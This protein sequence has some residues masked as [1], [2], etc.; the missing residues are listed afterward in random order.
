MERNFCRCFG[1]KVQLKNF[2]FGPEDDCVGVWCPLHSWVK[3]MHSPGLLHVWVEFGVNHA[4]F[5][6]GEVH[7]EEA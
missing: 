2:A 7:N 3:T 6:S 1:R 4:L 5:A